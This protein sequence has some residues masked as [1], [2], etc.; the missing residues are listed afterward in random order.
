LRGIWRAAWIIWKATFENIGAGLIEKRS[1]PTLSSMQAKS[2]PIRSS[3][4]A[5]RARRFEREIALLEAMDSSLWRK[6]WFCGSLYF[7]VQV[8]IWAVLLSI[9]TGPDFN[10]LEL[11]L[12]SLAGAVFTALI[13]QGMGYGVGIFLTIL[14]AVAAI[15]LFE[16]GDVV[17]LSG[18]GD[19]APA[20]ED[21]K[22]R[23]RMR[24]ARAISIRREHLRRRLQNE[25]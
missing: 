2:S 20:K 17:D 13:V 8:A 15:I 23:L 21:P 10:G 25:T 5:R 16:S 24:V 14:I 9:V 4:Q 6:A 19:G 12:L 3:L 22:T 18:Y 1:V 11:A 7:G